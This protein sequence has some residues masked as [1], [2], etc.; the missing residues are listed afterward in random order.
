MQK[1]QETQFENLH[2]CP[3]CS[4]LFFNE[5]ALYGHILQS[6]R[7]GQYMSYNMNADLYQ[8]WQ[9]RIPRPRQ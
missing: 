2:I 1:P 8:R 6:H 5:K 9:E 4:K 3:V 7:D